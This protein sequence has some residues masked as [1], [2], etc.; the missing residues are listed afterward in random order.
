MCSILFD[1]Y[2]GVKITATLLL[3]VSICPSSPSSSI[4]AAPTATSQ[5]ASPTH[6]A[7]L[8]PTATI[9]SG[10][11]YLT[12]EASWSLEPLRR[13]EPFGLK[14]LDLLSLLSS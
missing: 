1:K 3:P 14:T 11:Q 8:R 6:A 13:Q 12:T 10:R 2:Q 4:R 5:L 7:S 9:L